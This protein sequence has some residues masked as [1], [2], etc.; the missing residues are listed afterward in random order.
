MAQH[1][2]GQIAERVGKSES[3]IRQW[4]S[5]LQDELG[6]EIGSTE[7]NRTNSNLKGRKTFNDLEVQR[8]IAFGTKSEKTESVETPQLVHIRSADI[9][10]L[11][12]I[13]DYSTTIHHDLSELD[14]GLSLLFAQSDI[15]DEQLVSVA[16]SR[17]LATGHRMV[18][19]ELEGVA[20]GYGDAK[21]QIA[22][23]QGLIK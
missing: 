8:I 18:A 22:K 10:Q 23:N 14:Q 1:T 12:E 15:I 21:K 16:R 5:K 20:T 9:V 7:S 19:A 6:T 3:T 13:Q 4:V 2:Y 17:G 11:T